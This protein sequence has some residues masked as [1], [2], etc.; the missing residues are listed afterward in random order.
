V[1]ESSRRDIRRRGRSSPVCY[2]APPPI[3][4]R[5]EALAL[6]L[7]VQGCCVDLHPASA[8]QSVSVALTLTS[9]LSS[10]F[11]AQQPH[12]GGPDHR[13]VGREC[14]L[15]ALEPPLAS[16]KWGGVAA[17]CSAYMLAQATC[18]GTCK[19]WRFRFRGIGM[20]LVE[21]GADWSTFWVARNEERIS[22]KLFHENCTSGTPLERASHQPEPPVFRYKENSVI[23][24]SD[25]NILCTAR[26][27]TCTDVGVPRGH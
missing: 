22:V 18:V 16:G 23:R 12:G 19:W 1:A 13:L 2:R 8:S 11:K 5:R 6:P 20:G 15:D 26:T 14:I 4:R 10:P 9:H 3:G 25:R 24:F 27:A 7:G 21:I 17:V